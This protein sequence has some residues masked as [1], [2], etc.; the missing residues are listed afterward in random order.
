MISAKH[1]AQDRAQWRSTTGH[2][3]FEGEEAVED[4]ADRNQAAARAFIL[5]FVI[6]L[7]F[8]RFG[9]ADAAG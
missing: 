8:R 2:P 9:Y 7:D 4:R 1:L 6:F 3:G 5:I